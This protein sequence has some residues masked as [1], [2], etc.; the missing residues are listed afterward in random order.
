MRILVSFDPEWVLRHSQDEL[1]PADAVAAFIAD[2]GF[3]TVVHQ[4]FTDVVVE[5]PDQ[6]QGET[7][8]EQLY[9]HLCELFRL[10]TAE[11]EAAFKI[12]VQGRKAAAQKKTPK[13]EAPV[14]I[15]RKAPKPPVAPVEAVKE[16]ASVMEQVHML[17]GAGQFVALCDNIHAM[18]PVLRQRKLESVCASLSY[19]FSIDD[20][21]GHTTAVE[22]LSQLLTQEALFQG[23]REP[24]E[25]VLKAATPQS[26][27][28]HDVLMEIK[29]SKD[30]VIS[31]DI[32]NWCD[33]VSTPEF[34]NF[35]VKLRNLQEQQVF[36]FRLPY[37]EHAVL[38]GIEE[39]IADVMRVQKVVFPPMSAADLQII[40]QE[41]LEAKGFTATP[42]A[43]ELF[44]H[45]LAA[46]KSDGRFYGIR[47]AENIMQD[48]IFL[49]VQAI[50]AGAAGDE[51]VIDAPERTQLTGVAQQDFSAEELLNSMVGMD[52]LR[53]KIY[54]FL[55]QI[56]YAK[57]A[58][59]VNAPAMHMRFV[60]NPGTG[61]TT[62][63]R[64]LGQLMKE[65]GLLSK[66][67]FFEHAGGDFIGMY[68]GHTAPKTLALC[69]DA[70]GSVLFI[71][72][73]YTLANANYRDNSGYAKE[74]IDTL[75]AQMENHRDDMMVIMAGYPQD[76]E[77]LMALNP[78]LSGRMPYVLEFPNYSRQ[79]L[80]Q[81]FMRMAQKSAFTL[82]EEAEAA[83]KAYFETLDDSIL[84]GPDFSNA[85]F[86]RNLFERTW[87]KTVT[88]SQFDAGDCRVITRADF[89]AAV[90]E[91]IQMAQNK[92]PKRTRPG[93]HVGLI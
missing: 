31:V 1:L 79:E 25:L 47:T 93:Y 62:V 61:K 50:V 48:M 86:V 3:G 72:E 16:E 28:L 73:A 46:E 56:E 81:I 8:G 77:R 41:K 89:E 88:R 13:P 38:E 15:P 58:Q 55:N 63:A 57:K 69:R 80:T 30:R 87:S 71:D 23:K 52:Q 5:L 19:L 37:L 82:S 68:V 70:Y 54:E 84:N 6:S 64:I 45:R 27:P 92:T 67:F 83:A 43:W 74:A 12:D 11:A 65:R 35:L 39:A 66:G 78:G 26:D 24:R 40:A 53:E 14:S 59:G 4:D 42:A 33:K 76:M 2:R 18:A 10:N 36:V 7:V 22:L 32:S 51:N 49:K 21:C 34:R 44:Q 20:G 17:H 60:G 90:A 85:R 75:I 29:P 9:Q 91:Q